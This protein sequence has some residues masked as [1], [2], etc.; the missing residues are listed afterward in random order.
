MNNQITLNYDSLIFA[1][2]EL[3]QESF[4]GRNYGRHTIRLDR[5]T[6][7]CK[8]AFDE[9]EC[10]AGDPEATGEIE[11]IFDIRADSED[12]DEDVIFKAE[13]VGVE[14]EMADAVATAELN[15]WGLLGDRDVELD[16]KGLKLDHSHPIGMPSVKQA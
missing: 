7:E 6:G 10:R 2:D 16:V 4:I 5:E 9:A 12:A 15:A 11:V 1:M 3:M 8:Y 14:V 13:I